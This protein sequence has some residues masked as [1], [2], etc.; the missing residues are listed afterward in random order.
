MVADDPRSQA[1]IALD[2]VYARDSRRILATLIR[3]LGDFDQ[4]EEAMQDAFTVALERWV[5][6]GIPTKIGSRVS[7]A[8]SISCSTRAISPRPATQPYARIC[9]WKQSISDAC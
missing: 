3:L 8:S 6:E 5:R 1:R 2:A 7:G 4:A 9:Q